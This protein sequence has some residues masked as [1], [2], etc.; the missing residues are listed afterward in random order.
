[1]RFTP[2]K[3]LS[4]GERSVPVCFGVIRALMQR[5]FGEFGVLKHGIRC[6]SL[7]WE[8]CSPSFRGPHSSAPSQNQRFCDGVPVVHFGVPGQK[9]IIF[10]WGKFREPHSVFLPHSGRVQSPNIGVLLPPSCGF[11]PHLPHRKFFRRGPRS[12]PLKGNPPFRGTP[13]A[14]GATRSNRWTIRFHPRGVKMSEFRDSSAGT[15]SEASVSAFSRREKEQPR[16]RRADRCNA[17]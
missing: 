15:R 3:I 9:F 4:A 12:F 10:D 5:S 7:T 8:Y 16:D 1:M 2:P 11:P 6:T 17:A 13:D 14:I